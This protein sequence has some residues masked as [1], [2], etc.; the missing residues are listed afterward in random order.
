MRK[1]V[2]Y[3]IMF[4]IAIFLQFGLAFAASNLEEGVKILAEQISKSMIERQS[5][6]I[7][8]IDFSDLNGNVTDLGRF[9]AEELTTQLFTIASGKFEI[10]ERRKLLKLEE[11]LALSQT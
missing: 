9:M 10:M 8:V 11:E 6:K 5:K 2:L 4:L 1:V 3:W 7:A